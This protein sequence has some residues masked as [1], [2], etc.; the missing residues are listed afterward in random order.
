VRL[1]LGHGSFIRGL[2]TTAR[3]DEKTDEFVLNTPTITS[4]KWWPGNLGKSS[5]Y[6]VVMAQLII[7]GKDLGLHSFIVQL[8]SLQDHL[9]LPGVT[10][11]DIGPKFGYLGNDNGFLILKDVRIPR[12]NMLMRYAKVDRQG[13]YSTPPH[14]KLGYA[15]MV[16]MRTSIVAESAVQLAKACTIAVRYSAVRRQFFSESDPKPTQETKILDYQ[17]QQHKLFPLVAQSF[18]IHFTS[19]QMQKL[20]DK[21]IELVSKGNLSLMA[22]VHATSSCLKALF[23]TLSCEGMETA[24][25]SLGGHGYSRFCGSEFLRFRLFGFKIS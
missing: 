19:I 21:N 14:S 5:N 3:F 16:L 7:K 1:E 20:Y 25:K 18:M 12:E 22:E 17:T 4:M 13:N 6:C 23:T 9:P 10:V 8:R 24:R 2:E 15:T 11:G